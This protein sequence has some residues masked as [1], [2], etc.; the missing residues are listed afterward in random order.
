MCKNAIIN[1]LSAEKKKTETK[2]A[3]PDTLS[4]SSKTLILG[5]Q[6][7]FDQRTNENYFNQQENS[8]I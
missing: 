2:N 8:L 6:N 4:F 5:I 1:K 7:F 3:S